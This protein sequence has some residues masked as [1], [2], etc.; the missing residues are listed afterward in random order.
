[1]HGNQDVK[2]MDWEPNAKQCE[3]IFK[4]G[5]DFSSILNSL[6]MPLS[7]AVEYEKWEQHEQA[8]FKA[9]TKMK[10]YL[11]TFDEYKEVAEKEAEC[12]L[13]E[14][15]K[16]RDTK[17]KRMRLSA[18]PACVS[19][20]FADYL[21]VE[22]TGPDSLLPVQIFAPMDVFKTEAEQ[23]VCDFFRTPRHIMYKKACPGNPWSV[24]SDLHYDDMRGKI[25]KVHSHFATMDAEAGHDHSH[26]ELKAS[27]FPGW[28][29]N[30]SS[31]HQY[32]K[33]AAVSPMIYL[34]RN[35]YFDVRPVCVPHAHQR[36]CM[37]IVQGTALVAV[38]SAAQM[39]EAGDLGSVLEKAHHTWM[40]DT[41]VFKLGPGDALLVPF[42][43]T[44]VTL[45]WPSDEDAAKK[46]PKLK[47]KRDPADYMSYIVHTPFDYAMDAQHSKEVKSEVLSR[48][49]AGTNWMPTK[50]KHC[51]QVLKWK[52]VLEG[53]DPVAEAAPASPTT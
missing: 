50:L 13:V 20:V 52:T 2:S 22:E 42:G 12:K 37:Q 30:P 51:D 47:G 10:R 26:H 4:A 9:R 38:L 41:P 7:F 5:K 40:A 49:V 15:R 46:A 23:T 18:V 1:M 32:F 35:F 43:N 8:M 27:E 33:V 3:A 31:E 44:A 11:Q 25:M 14:E 19:K 34:L 6:K 16:E 45:A 53:I 24:P 21:Q 39:R 36:H 29:F 28:P 17:S 48:Y